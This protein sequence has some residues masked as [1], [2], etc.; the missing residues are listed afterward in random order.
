MADKDEYQGYTNHATWVVGLHLNNTKAWQDTGLAL[1]AT[2]GEDTGRCAD[3]LKEYVERLL[4]VGHY[5]PT[6]RG[7]FAVDLLL[8][9][10]ADVDW[11]QLAG[12]LRDTLN[13]G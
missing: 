8:S 5:W 12:H 4:D 6:D 1:M 11:K 10:L 3:L 9:S 13:E 7:R 2:C